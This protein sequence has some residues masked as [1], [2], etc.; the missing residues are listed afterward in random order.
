MLTYCFIWNIIVVDVR[1]IPKKCPRYPESVR[2]IPKNVR[3]I[4]KM[5]PRYPEKC[6]RYP[7]K[8]PRYPEK[9]VPLIFKCPRYPE[10]LSALSRKESVTLVVKRHYFPP[11]SEFRAGQA[12]ARLGYHKS[13]VES[14]VLKKRPWAF[15][16][17]TA[18]DK[19]RVAFLRAS[20]GAAF[21]LLHDI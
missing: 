1:A 3:A 6:P 17:A 8:C 20:W 10:H 18:S 4:P 11:C 13:K 14:G 5:C 16:L 19:N 2:A 12:Q 7:E 9:R 21:F 15:R